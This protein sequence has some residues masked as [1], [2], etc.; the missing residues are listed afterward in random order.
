LPGLLGQ[1]EA[2]RPLGYP[3]A[4]RESYLPEYA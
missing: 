1:S 3:E 2:H 4:G